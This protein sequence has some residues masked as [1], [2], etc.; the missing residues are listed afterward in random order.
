MPYT[1]SLFFVWEWLTGY[2]MHA[3]R[4]VLECILGFEQSRNPMLAYAVRFSR[5]AVKESKGDTH[6]CNNLLFPLLW[7]DMFFQHFFMWP[8]V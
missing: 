2:Q 1:G 4:M 5:I 8:I 3:T 6:S 7:S